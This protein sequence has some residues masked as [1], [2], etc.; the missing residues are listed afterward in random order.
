MITACARHLLTITCACGILMGLVGCGSQSA[1]ADAAQAASQCVQHYQDFARQNP[2]AVDLPTLIKKNNWPS[3]DKTIGA[4][5]GVDGHIDVLFKYEFIP[6]STLT[7][8]RSVVNGCAFTINGSFTVD[9]IKKVKAIVEASF[10]VVLQ[11]VY[12]ERLAK[13]GIHYNSPVASYP[14]VLVKFQGNGDSGSIFVSV[15]KQP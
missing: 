11:E 9:D 4:A 2:G 3:K 14:D 12:F 7:P 13:T 15:Q 10:G 6:P 8:E 1:P 5:V